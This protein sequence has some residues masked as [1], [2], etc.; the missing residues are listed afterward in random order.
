MHM[1][2]RTV[3]FLALLTLTLPAAAS[4]IFHRTLEEVLEEADW[5]V[6]AT[7]VTAQRTSNQHSTDATYKLQVVETLQGTAPAVP[8]HY[9]QPI[10]IL[11]DDE[12]NEIGT[13]SPILDGSGSE[14]GL[15]EGET[16]IFV[17]SGP[18]SEAAQIA[19]LFRVEPRANL[20]A[21]TAWL[22]VKATEKTELPEPEKGAVER[23]LRGAIGGAW[24]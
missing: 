7:V 3:V 15:K 11:Y 4:Q 8:V 18:S 17:G 13:F 12:G 1:L 5:I 23:S 10:P 20:G 2:V 21:V 24:R 16:W 9:S 6:V 14:L 19:S 22:T